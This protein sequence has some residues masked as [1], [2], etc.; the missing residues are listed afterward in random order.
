MTTVTL[1]HTGW[2]GFAPVY[3]GR[4]WS[5]CP[6]LH[7]RI[8]YTGWLIRLNAALFNLVGTTCGHDS[9][10]PIRVASMLTRPKEVS[11]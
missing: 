6:V 5:T 4:T 2:L 10:F 1:T 8:P 7:P 3:I 11:L 9:G